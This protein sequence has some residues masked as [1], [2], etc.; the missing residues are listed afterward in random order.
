[1][2]VEAGKR[3]RGEPGLLRT[4]RNAALKNYV[5]EGRSAYKRM[6]ERKNARIVGEWWV[7]PG[8]THWG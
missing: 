5:N 1:M 4:S 2:I 3:V 8:V 6:F 7:V